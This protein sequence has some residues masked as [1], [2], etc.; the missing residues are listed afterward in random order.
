MRERFWIP[1][2]I[3]QRAKGGEIVCI[4]QKVQGCCN[5]TDDGSFTGIPHNRV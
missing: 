1:K 4:M 3:D 5:A 2:G